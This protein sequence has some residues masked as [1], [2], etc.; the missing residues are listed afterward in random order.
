[1]K[2]NPE[3][4][5]VELTFLIDELMKENPNQTVIRKLMVGQGI[6]YSVDPIT[7]MGTVLTLMDQGRTVKRFRKSESEI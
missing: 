2:R 6:P 5:A 1:M 7:Q 3:N 4:G